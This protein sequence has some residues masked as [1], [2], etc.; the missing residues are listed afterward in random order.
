MG[1]VYRAADTCRHEEVALKTLK[2]A[3]PSAIARLKEEF[4]AL[5]DVAHRN[6]VAL[7]DLGTEG[8]QWFFTMELVRGT[9]FLTYVQGGAKEAD[10]TVEAQTHKAGRRGARLRAALIQLARG[11]HAI[12]VARKLHCDIK[13]SNVMVD[14]NGRVVILD[15]GLVTDLAPEPW[16]RPLSDARSEEHTS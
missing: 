6:L 10:A 12:H 16:Q 15:F 14:H 9:D 2:E 11:I 3:D 13:P 5:A 1:V 4:R 8:D 7:Y